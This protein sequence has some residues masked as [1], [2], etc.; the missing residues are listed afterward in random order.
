MTSPLRK[1]IQEAKEELKRKKEEAGIEV[2]DRLVVTEDKGDGEEETTAVDE[3][4]RTELE[5][6]DEGGGGTEASPGDGR[7]EELEQELARFEKHVV[8]EES[9][10]LSRISELEKRVEQLELESRGDIESRIDELESRLEALDAP[11][12]LDDR[13]T[14][15]EDL[16]TDSDRFLKFLEEKGLD[17]QLEDL[18][19]A[20]QEDLEAL[21]TEIRK[22]DEEVHELKQELDSIEN[23]AGDGDSSGRGLEEL[24]QEIDTELTDLESRVQDNS[25]EI[26]D[27]FESVVELTE[28]MKQEFNR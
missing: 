10:E 8:E 20:L 17:D 1:S 7:I 25:Q 12:S 15:L 27:V 14:E 22:L 6:L 28:I 13:L 3:Q 2:H 23:Q 21:K 11:Q 26:D 4:L 16:V 9:E 5:E 18:A 24:R 19:P